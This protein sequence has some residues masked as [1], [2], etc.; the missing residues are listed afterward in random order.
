MRTLSQ[1][2]LACYRLQYRLRCKCFSLLAA[3]AFAGFGRRTALM[4]PIQLAGEERIAL[5]DGVYVGSGSWLQ[6]LPDGGNKE[7]AI[8]IGGGTSIAGSCVISAARSVTLEEEVL[9]AR[10]VYISD[11]IH[12]YDD[13]EVAI[14]A[15]GIAKILPVRIKRGAWLGQNVVICPGVTIGRGSVIGANSVVNRDI[16]DFTLA[17]GVPAKVIKE[18]ASHQ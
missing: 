18:I 3:G 6:T 8:K 5:G 7:I 17:A 10:N 15:Q 1:L 2:A 13:G 4:L 11:H 9:L 12:R 14:L 16:P